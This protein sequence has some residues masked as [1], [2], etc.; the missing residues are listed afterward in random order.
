MPAPAEFKKA[1]TNTYWVTFENGKA[2]CVTCT[3]AEDPLAVA[4][5]LGTVRTIDSLPYPAQPV[6]RRA[7]GDTCPE[8]CYKPQQCKGHTA[9]PQRYA[10]SE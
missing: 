5:E 4:G 8:F 9:C 1:Y 2:G 7:A 3:E 6:L 10:C